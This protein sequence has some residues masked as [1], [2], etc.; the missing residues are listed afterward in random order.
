[1]KKSILV[2]VFLWLVSS[3][4]YAK[5]GTNNFVF[6]KVVVVI[7]MPMIRYAIM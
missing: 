2:L 3:S 4:A 1:M 7:N 5:K 6:Q